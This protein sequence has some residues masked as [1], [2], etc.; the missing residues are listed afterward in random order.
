M[1][2]GAPEDRETDAIGVAERR[3][4]TEVVTLLERF[5]EN[6][7][8]IREAMRLELGWYDV[9]AAEIFALVVFVSDGLLQ[10]K[11]TTTTPA[12]RFFNIARR[13]PL[14][15]QMIICHRVVGSTKEIIPGKD[16]EM[17]FKSLAENLLWSSIF[18]G[19]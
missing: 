17:A 11:D 19:G 8:K 10:F 16:S 14:E 7:E 6:P 3:G 2:L 12:A 15:L 9:A 18:T 5:K 4:E 13:L 1:N